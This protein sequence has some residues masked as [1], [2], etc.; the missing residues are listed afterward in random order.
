MR[1]RIKG[2][3]VYVR[4]PSTS[5]AD[6]L[7]NP[8]STWS[9]PE[10]VGNVLVAVGAVVDDLEANRPEGVS[11]SYTLVFP[12]SYTDSLRGCEIQVPNDSEWYH[13][14]G[15]PK[16]QIDGQAILSYNGRNRVVEVTRDDG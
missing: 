12:K 2:V 9:D 10:T 4:R 16:P 3:S 15:D 14:I 5:G 11:V 7:G 8:V 1:G 13:V 6:W